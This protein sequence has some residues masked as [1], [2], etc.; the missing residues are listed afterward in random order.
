MLGSDNILGTD[1]CIMIVS[2]TLGDADRITI[3]VDEGIVMGSPYGSFD[4]SN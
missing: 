3:G 4:G 1:D 2:T